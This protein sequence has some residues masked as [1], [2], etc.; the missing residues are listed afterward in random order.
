MD[1]HQHN[2]EIHAN[3]EA[4]EKKT[5]LRLAYR[6]LY[7]NI[8]EEI[9]A[10]P[11]GV[12]AEVGSGMG[13]IKEFLPHCITSDLFPNPWLDRVENIYELNFS[14]A[15]VSHLILFD[16]WHHL[17]YPA[18]ALKEAARV[19]VKGGKL[20]L[21]EPA[22]SLLGRIVY[23]NFHH[24]PLGFDIRISGEHADMSTPEATR[25]FAAQSSAY[26]IFVRRELPG[27]LQGWRVDRVKQIT[28]F[29][30]LG[31][32]GFSGAQLYPD[33]AYPAIGI[34]DK[35]LGL[36]PSFFAARILVVLTK[37]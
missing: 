27:L 22:M 25:Y 3:R 16:V 29:A 8:C 31:S 26:R 24:E 15:S 12:V 17:E 20:I 23:G 28:S 30:Y 35:L 33:F 21:M 11:E 6:E 13:N 32:G 1:I 7:K 5:S 10:E 37:K 19:L 2:R 34:M 14:S 36:F 18:N 4:W 9:Q